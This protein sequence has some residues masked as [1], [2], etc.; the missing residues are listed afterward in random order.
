[1]A[2]ETTDPRI[3]GE[4]VRRVSDES[5]RDEV[6]LVGVVHNH[7]AS[8]YRVRTTLGAADPDV[9]ALELPP[10]AVPLY[11]QYADDRRTPP[12]FGGE[13][14]AAIQAV[15]TD[16]IVGIDGPS[17]AFVVRLLR[18]LSTD[19][20]SFATVQ[21]VLRGLS[22]VTK[23][24]VVC[25]LAATLAARTDVRLE[26]GSPAI[27]D[28]DRADDPQEQASDERSQIRRAQTIAKTFGQS[29]TARVRNVTREEHM[30]DQLS[31]LRR[32]GNVVAVVGI[33]HLDPLT[34]RLAERTGR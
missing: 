3:T 17:S 8:K 33:A 34:H 22:S 21:S 30:A 18:T 5:H 23:R 11:E 10:L 6:T 13:M 20:T 29:D 28:C 26:V 25:R 7:P 16:R 27:H 24:A 19:N 2:N 1:M 15:T 4:Y 32:D 14:S 31:T 12:P 9:L